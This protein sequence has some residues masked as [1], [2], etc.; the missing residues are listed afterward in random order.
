M[1]MN[2]STVGKSTKR[3][4]HVAEKRWLMRSASLEAIDATCRVDRPL[5]ITIW[6]AIDDL[7]ASGIEMVSTA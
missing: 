3:F 2:S 6:S 5:A 4:R 7:P 1:P